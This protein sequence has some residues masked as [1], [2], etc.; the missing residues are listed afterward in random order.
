MKTT[1]V[2]GV[3]SVCLH[4]LDVSHCITVN[5]VKNLDPVQKSVGIIYQT[6]ESTQ[7]KNNLCSIGHGAATYGTTFVLLYQREYA[8]EFRLGHIVCS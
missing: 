5:V 7:I 2:F 6:L 3:Y 8:L 1:S 4:E